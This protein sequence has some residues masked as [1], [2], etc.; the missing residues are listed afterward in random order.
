MGGISSEGLKFGLFINGNWVEG[1]KK[2]DVYNPFNNQVIGSVSEADENDVDKAVSSAKDAF[3]QFKDMPLY[4][5][6]SYLRKISE[7]I[8][9]RKDKIAR[10]IT[11]ES[12]KAIRFSTG[13]VD[14]AVETFKFA[15]DEADKLSGETVPL[16]AARGG[17]NRIGFYIRVPIGPAVAITPFNFPLNLAAHK[18]APALAAGDTVVWKP[19]TYTPLT[20]GLF[21]EIIQDV[22]IPEGVLNVIFGP[23]DAVGE[24]LIK[25]KDIKLISFTG[26]PVVGK[27]LRNISGMKKT[28]LELGS[29]SALVIDEGVENLE[30]VVDRAIIGS[31]A[32]AGQV[33][34][35][36]Q[37]IYAHSSIFEEFSHLFVEKAKEITTGDPL[38]P[39]VLYGP[40]IT[41]GEA[42]RA[43]KWIKEALEMGARPLLLGER[44]GAMYTPTVLT[45][46]TFDMKVVSREVFAPVVSIMP[47]NT[48]D[49]AIDMV[50][51]SE[52]G[53]NVGIYTQSISNMMKAIKGCE[54]G[55]VVINDYPTFRVDNM[56]YGGVKMSG[57]GREG[58]PFAIEEYTEIRFVA[59][60]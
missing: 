36:I 48:I 45:D 39:E 14:R 20:A 42:M 31:Y 19:S 26:S 11:L 24:A 16:D 2:I 37:R 40:M 12:G 21:A 55:S 22:G 15:A 30:D 34:I 50:N 58:P 38:N 51:H 23:G 9:K 53:L 10:T 8:S 27:K 60:K 33:C 56:P 59:I 17:V 49:Q 3:Q 29:N 4:L 18:I 43:E 25:N 7:A 57:M 52:Y 35:S 1:K 46:V 6:A 44:R 54:V 13:E 28:L 47:F 41:E 32:N 5:R